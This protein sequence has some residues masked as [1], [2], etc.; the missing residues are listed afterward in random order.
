MGHNGIHAMDYTGKSDPYLIFLCPEIGVDYE[1]DDKKI[2]KSQ[3][4]EQTLEPKW[5][6]EEIPIL[7]CKIAD[8]DVLRNG[9]LVL[10][11]Q[12]HDR[13]DDDDDMGYGYLPLAKYVDM[14]EG[15]D[16]SVN[17][18]LNGQQAGWIK[19]HIC[20]KYPSATGQRDKRKL[21]SG[22]CQCTLL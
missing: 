22:G 9:H 1:G 16:F 4:K 12:D 15:G 6:D 13:V 20:F 5:D 19:G 2:W 14:P 3:W 21:K 7:P 11:M 17:I 18:S 10:C 8:K